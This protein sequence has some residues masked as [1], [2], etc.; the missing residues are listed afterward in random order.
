MSDRPLPSSFDPYN[1][2][3]LRI[4]LCSVLPVQFLAVH[5]LIT[6]PI[7]AGC[8]ATSYA[9]LRAYKSMKAG[10]S[11][12]L[13]RMFRFRIYAQAFTLLAGVGG[14]FYYQAERAQRKEL[15]RAV[16]DKKAQAKRDAWLRELEIRDQ[17]DR[18]WRERHEAVGKAAK[19]AG[20]KPKEANLDAP[21]VPTKES[22]EAKPTGGI[23]DAVKSLGKEK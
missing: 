11:A 5:E 12:Q 18:E 8:L 20:N 3:L 10:D 6:R 4:L 21:K 16:A 19:E 2:Y 9:L 17:E 13:N 15:E 1:S 23:L 22:E 7:P 14:G